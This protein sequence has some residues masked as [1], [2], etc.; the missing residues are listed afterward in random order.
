MS[1][2]TIN[3][4]TRD[5]D[6]SDMT[7]ARF[8][9]AA[10]TNSPIPEARTTLLPVKEL[11]EDLIQFYLTNIYPLYP[12][13]PADSLSMLLDDIYEDTRPVKSSDYWLFWVALAIGSAAQSQHAEDSCAQNGR[14]FIARALH[15]ADR[16]LMPG[17]VNQLKALLL[18]TL[19]SLLDPAHFDSWHLIGF[20]CRAA[21]DLGYHH[22]PPSSQSTEALEERRRLFYCIYSLDRSV[23]T[24]CS[25]GNLFNVF[26]RTI[27]MVWT[28][29]FSF[30]DDAITTTMP[31]PNPPS[32]HLTSGQRIPDPSVHLFKLRRLQSSWYQTLCQSDPHDPHPDPTSYKWNMCLRMREWSEG[33]PKNLLPSIRDMLDLELRYSYV[34]CLAPSSRAPGLTPYGR[35]LIFEHAIAYIARMYE[36]AQGST[37]TGFYTYH[38]A[39]RVYF[40]GT[41]FHA[42]LNGAVDALLSGPSMPGPLAA[43]TMAPPPP[44]PERDDRAE[45]GD[46]LDRSLRTLEKV[47]ALLGIYAERW[48]HA[49]RLMEAYG[50]VSGG[51]LAELKSRKEMRDATSNQGQH[52]PPTSHGNGGF[53]QAM[54]FQHMQQQQQQ[55]DVRWLDEDVT[56]QYL[57][58]RA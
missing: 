10:V 23:Y 42:A 16:A 40:M 44:L 33:L 22:E 27:S 39:L 26:T 31:A 43:P 20:T 15:Y 21:I 49:S 6:P 50:M 25:P 36:I 7:F 8:V 18:F 35:S 30:I 57:G 14:E 52:Q 28:R 54:H 29:P 51:L 9:L 45:G 12:I 19:Y 53:P 2:R 47:S 56:Q 55:A 58:G 5:F 13:F 32:S 11:A 41:Q 34:Y 1:S 48:E 17:Y 4:T 46:N 38:D 37:N 24:L 3:A